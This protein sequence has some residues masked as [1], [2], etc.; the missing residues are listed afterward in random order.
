[1]PVAAALCAPLALPLLVRAVTPGSS[2]LAFALGAL[3]GI[4]AARKLAGPAV[5]RAVAFQLAYLLIAGA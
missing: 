4:G 1:L 3:L 5:G 2:A